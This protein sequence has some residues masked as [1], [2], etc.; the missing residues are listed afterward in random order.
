MN[1]PQ[2]KLVGKVLGLTT[3]RKRLNKIEFFSMASS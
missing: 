1:R 2:E 3:K